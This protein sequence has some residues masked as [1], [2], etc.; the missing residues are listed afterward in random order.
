MKT[1][2]KI[3]VEKHGFDLIL[4]LRVTHL[5]KKR[6]PT[7]LGPLTF[8][9]SVCW[10]DDQL[11]LTR[12]GSLVSGF[13]MFSINFK[14]FDLG[15]RFRTKIFLISPK[16]K[17]P[18][19][20]KKDQIQKFGQLVFGTHPVANMSKPSFP[21]IKKLR[22]EEGINSEK[23]SEKLVFWCLSKQIRNSIKLKLCEVK[24]RNLSFD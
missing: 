14:H 11:L 8:S 18:F 10:E 13:V 5:D 2:E 6:F 3:G 16:F 22:L 4:Y 19:P 1:T 12:K 20:S 17:C 15:C 9:N 7:L 24:H 23:I 21:E